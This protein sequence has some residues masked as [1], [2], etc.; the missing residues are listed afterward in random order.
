MLVKTLLNHVQPFKGFVYK[1]AKLLKSYDRFIWPEERIVIEV[2][3]RKNSKPIC[4]GCGEKRPG[5][6]KLPVRLYDYLPVL[7]VLVY[8]AYQPRRVQCPECGIKVES[9]PWSD[10]KNQLTKTLQW[11]LASWAKELSWKA[12][13][14]RF[15]V[16]WD[17]VCKSVEMAV[18]WGLDNRSL[19]GVKSIGVDEISHAKGH[20][21]LTLVYQIDQG[22]RRLLWIGEKR[23]EESFKVFFDWL[24]EAKSKKI[25]AVCSDMW[26]AYLKVIKERVPSAIH[27]L[28]RFHIAQHLNK[29][30]DQVRAEEHKR[31][32]KDGYE[33]ILFKQRWL[34]LRGRKNLKEEQKITLREMLKYNLKTMRAY[35]LKEDF[36]RFLDL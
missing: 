36:N 8:F 14:I 1:N 3:P 5:Y 24:G 12:V 31:L 15:K 11:F 10:G 22:M 16:S 20:Q 27:V 6:D 33:S 19:E 13:A 28:D 23:T 4:S 17:T 7:G 29:A 35:L 2:V 34:L 25:E 32:L 30:I 18:E 21:Y 9:V 26:S